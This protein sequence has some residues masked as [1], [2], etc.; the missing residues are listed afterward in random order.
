MKSTHINASIVSLQFQ[1]K[2]L[3]AR[4]FSFFLCYLFNLSLSVNVIPCPGIFMTH[5]SWILCADIPTR[6]WTDLRSQT[7]PSNLWTN[8][9]SFKTTTCK[10]QTD[11]DLDPLQSFCSHVNYLSYSSQCLRGRTQLTNNCTPKRTFKEKSKVQPRKLW[12]E[13]TSLQSL[14]ALWQLFFFF[15]NWTE[16]FPAAKTK[17]LFLFPSA[18]ISG[19][20][21]CTRLWKTARRTQ[22]CLASVCEAKRK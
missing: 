14:K 5:A 9:L 16:F 10:H 18:V 17:S 1:K 2:C 6:I 12:F 8:L 7:Q 11:V 20:M 22:M 19:C 3:D 4:I 13:Y 21:E 15:Y